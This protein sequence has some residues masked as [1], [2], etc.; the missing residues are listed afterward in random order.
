VLTNIGTTI[1]VLREGAHY[2]GKILLIGFYNPDATILAGSNTLQK[3]LNENLEGLVASEAYGPNVKLA[4]PFP[5]FN[6]EAALFK[7]GETAKEKEK[8]EKKER[9]TICK[10]TEMCGE[11]AFPQINGDIHPTAKG[12]K[13]IGKLMVEAF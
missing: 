9:S 3:I 2:T 7:E 6:P 1:G 10:L 12:Y 4:Q 8:K 5:V 11:T 13:T